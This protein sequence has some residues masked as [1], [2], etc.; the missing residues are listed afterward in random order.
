M[1]EIGTELRDVRIAAGLSQRHVAHVAGLSQSKISRTERAQRV[2]AR[3]D[4]LMAHGA[5]L[6]LRIS[7]K[8][9][10]EGSPVRDAR[11][12]RVVGRL[13]ERVGTAFEWRTDVLIGGYG[14]LRAGDVRLDGPGSIGI[15]VETRLSDMQELQ[16]RMEAKWR[17]SGVDRIV[18]V[19]AA[20]RH[21]RRV[22]AEHRDALLSTF[23]ADTP[24][25]MAALRR[26]RLPGST[27]IVVL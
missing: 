13:R 20:T 24:E 12:L 10:P 17:D 18:L 16:R 27:G 25:I 1:N 4:E 5:A 22:L 8:A 9:Y 21:N 23:P 15:D 11:Q 6:G 3:V 26:G 7:L 14:D 2:P 19:V